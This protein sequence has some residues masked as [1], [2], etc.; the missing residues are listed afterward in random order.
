MVTISSDVLTCQRLF[1]ELSSA[2]VSELDDADRGVCVSKA[3]PYS[4]A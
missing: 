2:D 4:G 3:E 1:Y